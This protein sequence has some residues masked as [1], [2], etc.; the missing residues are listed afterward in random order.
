MATG[1]DPISSR[2]DGRGQGVVDTSGKIGLVSD[3]ALLEKEKGRYDNGKGGENLYAAKEQA[4][5]EH[6][7]MSHDREKNNSCTPGMSNTTQN[8]PA[9]DSCAFN[10]ATSKH[11]SSSDP[12]AFGMPGENHRPNNSGSGNSWNE[13][14][15]DHSSGSSALGLKSDSTFSTFGMGSSASDRAKGNSSDNF[16]FGMSGGSSSP[17]GRDSSTNN[18]R[19]KNSSDNDRSKNSSLNTASSV[20]SNPMHKNDKANNSSSTKVASGMGYD[21]LKE[22]APTDDLSSSGIGDGSGPKEP[23]ARGAAP[24][25]PA[26]TKDPR[27]PAESAKKGDAKDKAADYGK[28]ATDPKANR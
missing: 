6:I 21:P 10:R 24:E 27:S 3:D 16:A 28:K 14:S 4:T 2:E 9:S 22:N 23:N 5:G 17:G 25:R 7:R 12:Y 11:S 1:G 26:N 8:S 18:N 15:K 13:T 20:E 19:S